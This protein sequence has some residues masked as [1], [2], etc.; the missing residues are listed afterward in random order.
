[1]TLDFNPFK[2][3]SGFMELLS[4]QLQVLRN[5]VVLSVKAALFKKE[6]LKKSVAVTKHV[7]RR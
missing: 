4:F 1:V 7:T 6:P 2:L 5:S 3:S